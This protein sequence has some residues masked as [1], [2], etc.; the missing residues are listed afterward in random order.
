MLSGRADIGYTSRWSD[1]SE[2]VFR[3]LFAD[4]FGVVFQEK[5]RFARHSGPLPCSE[6]EGERCVGLAE[7]TGIKVILRHAPGLPD[8]VTNPFYEASTTTS[9]DMMVAQGLGVAVLPALAAARPPISKLGF[10]VLAD[11]QATRTIGLITSPSRPL[12]PASERCMECILAAAKA[13]TDIPNVDL[14]RHERRP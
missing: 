6:L 11:P 12:S 9:L 3:P 4:M 10:R 7:D 2:V 8:A 1:G 13:V 5:H 14:V